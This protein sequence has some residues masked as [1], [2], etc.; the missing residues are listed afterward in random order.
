MGDRFE[1]NKN[2]AYCGK[3]NEDIWYAPTCNVY[4]FT[5]SKC[6]KY[7]FVTD[8]LMTKKLEDTTQEDVRN[9]FLNVTNVPWSDEDIERMTKRDFEE[10]KKEFLK[11]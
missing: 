3:L 4:G 2:C 10:L 11:K 5:C 8:G 7:N 6:K 1:L 9:A